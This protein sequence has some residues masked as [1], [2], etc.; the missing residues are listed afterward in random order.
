[1][2]ILSLWH[3]V[4]TPSKRLASEVISDDKRKRKVWAK[5]CNVYDGDTFTIIYIQDGVLC[6]RRCRCMGYDAPELKTKNPEEK[7]KALEAKEFLQSKLPKKI[8]RLKVNGLDKYGRFLV[9][10]KYKNKEYLKKI[11]I[12]NGFGYSYDGGTKQSFS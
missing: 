3:L 10:M 8:F 4:W 7:K 2:Y 11:M 12:E 6:K 5:I 9:D 1:M